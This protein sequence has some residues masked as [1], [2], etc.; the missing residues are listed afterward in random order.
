VL[1]YA[2]N[3]DQ[4]E[5]AQKV[6]KIFDSFTTKVPLQ[7]LLGFYVGQIVT[8]WWAQ[9]QMV[10][11]PDD[12]MVW[13]N[14]FFFKNDPITREKRRTIARY[15]ILT[16]TL[17]L[18]NVS[19]RIRKRFP[20]VESL[21]KAGLITQEECDLYHKAMVEN[22][23]WQLPLQWIINGIV[24]PATETKEIPGP[25]AGSII[26]KIND[27]RAALRSIFLYDW[28]CIPLVYTQT[29][30]VVVYGYFAFCLIGH[31]YISSDADLYI[32]YLTLLQFIFFV[33]WFK[34]AQ[35][36]MRPFG[37]DD[38]DMELNV[39]LDRHCAVAVNF[40]EQLCSLNP[41]QKSPPETPMNG[42]A[43]SPTSESTNFVE[44]DEPLPYFS[45]PYSRASLRSSKDHAPKMHAS[46][47]MKNPE[48][49]EL[50]RA[51]N[52]EAPDKTREPETHDTPKAEGDLSVKKTPVQVKREKQERNWF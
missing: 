33:G 18:R 2:L 45:L 14:A 34:V 35:D 46:V 22:I 25:G 12:V 16:E 17:V 38:D 47:K 8:R 5:H 21:I 13:T 32:P 7:F 51:K 9:V 48:E 30:S 37:E 11:W 27:F 4:F 36:L 24:V 15:L 26:G 49:A 52:F 3:K 40:A 44:D 10:P 6:V 39:I 28:V 1:L 43:N 42:E 50:I 41:S 23:R 19:T 29:C 20:T 31:Q